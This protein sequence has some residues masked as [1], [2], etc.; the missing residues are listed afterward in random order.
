VTNA[1]DDWHGFITIPSTSSGPMY[2]ADR[3]VSIH[4]EV[5]DFMIDVKH[6]VP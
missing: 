1:A 4:P 6:A 3:V 2:T 5:R